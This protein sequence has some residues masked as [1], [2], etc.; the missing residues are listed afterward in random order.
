MPCAS[1]LAWLAQGDEADDEAACRARGGAA[2]AP[3]AQRFPMMVGSQPAQRVGV[4]GV[5]GRNMQCFLTLGDDQVIR[6]KPGEPGHQN[7]GRGSCRSALADGVERR[8]MA[9]VV[10]G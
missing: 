2:S 4:E 9:A 6:E 10:L 3:R 5:N 7:I 8:S 1:P